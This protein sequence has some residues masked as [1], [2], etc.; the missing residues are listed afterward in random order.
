M[1]TRGFE[2]LLAE[3]FGVGDETDRR[4]PP[5]GRAADL[6]QRS[7]GQP[8]GEALAEQFLVA[9]DLDHGVARQRVDHADA[10]AMQAARRGIGLVGELA[11]RMERGHD[12]FQ[13]RLAGKFR[14]R[15]DR[16]AAPI[17]DDGQPVARFQRDF[18][19][20]GMPRHR[21]VH[22]VVQHLGRE[23]VQRALIR[24]ADIHAGTATHRLQP[25]QHLDSGSI[26]FRGG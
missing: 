14:V 19:P 2:L 12:H 15:I 17:I 8:L 26:I 24:A 10:H 11:A 23:M 9:C 22:A 6:F 3:D 1:Q 5:V 18:D 25:F 7:D 13:R 4:A 16:N 21:L 20:G